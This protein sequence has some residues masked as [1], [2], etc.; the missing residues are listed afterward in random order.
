M[1]KREKSLERPAKKN[2]V[3]KYCAIEGTYLWNYLAEE[4]K[5]FKVSLI[6]L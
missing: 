6:T 3:R 5:E 1:I 2:I 4:L